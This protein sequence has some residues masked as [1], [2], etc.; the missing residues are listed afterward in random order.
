MPQ[1]R[2]NPARENPGLKFSHVQHLG[3]VQVPWSMMTVKELQCAS[4]HQPDARGAGLVPVNFKNH[5]FE[6]HQDRFEFDPEASGRKLPHG[7]TA[8]L[9]DTLRDY[10]AGLA[11]RNHQSPQWVSASL[12]K[13]STDLAGE[14]GCAYCHTTRAST[15]TG[16]LFEIAPVLLV[17]NWFPAARFPHDRH[18]TTPCKDCHKVDQSEDSADIAIPDLQTCK[19]C[20]AGQTP[21]AGKVVSACMDCHAY[22]TAPAK[23]P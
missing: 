10:Y 18:A 8:E 7:S 9:S 1:S 6:C 23:K 17:R 15:K 14:E 20:H 2:I 16:N 3:K 12:A 22:H 5:C 11:F 19:Q 21:T 13:A 4:C